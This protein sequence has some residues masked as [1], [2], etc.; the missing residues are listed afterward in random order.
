MH[1]KEYTEECTKQLEGAVRIIAERMKEHNEWRV[2]FDEAMSKAHKKR[3]VKFDG[4]V[5]LE[6]NKGN[7]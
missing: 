5:K 1:N 3:E 6:I 7:G 4:L 2:K